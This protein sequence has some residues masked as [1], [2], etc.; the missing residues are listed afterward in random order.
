MFWKKEP[1]SMDLRSFYNGAV[2]ESSLVWSGRT[3]ACFHVASSFGQIHE[4]DPQ[5]RIEDSDL[6]FTQL[7]S[8]K[9]LVLSLEPKSSGIPGN[10]NQTPFLG[11]WSLIEFYIATV[12]CGKVQ[13]YKL[14]I[15]PEG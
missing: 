1:I 5:Q 13:V 15:N 9:P 2:H 11:S 10:A 14:G 12:T 3:L 7:A 4:Y 6:I 8:Y